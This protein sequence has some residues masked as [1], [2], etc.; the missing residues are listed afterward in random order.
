M[1]LTFKQFEAATTLLENSPESISDAVLLENNLTREDIETINEGLLGDIF[2]GLFKGLKE[3]ILKAVP[4]S[5]LK[6]VDA[7]LKEYKDTK[8]AI[9]DKTAKERD[10]IFKASLDD[11]E[12]PRNKEQITRSEKA[13]EAIEAA[14]KSKLD[15]IKTKLGI[16]SKDKSDIVKNYIDLQLAQIQEDVANKQLKDAED[17]ASEEQLDKLEAAVKEAKDKKDAAAKIIQDEASKKEASKKQSETDKAKNKEKKD[18]EAS[19][20]AN[21]PANAKAGD[22]FEYTDDAG[23]VKKAAI[24]KDQEEAK[25]K[26][27]DRIGIKLIPSGAYISA[28]P[29][30]LKKVQNDNK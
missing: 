17:N 21:D 14:S 4:G 16:V 6:K 27:A 11:K 20:K 24:A 30:R 28:K 5:V 13:I 10:K 12:S 26:G 29:D 23:K 15:A 9:S 8:L 25:K 3:K 22:E 19:K 2:G 1:K 18:S 7:I